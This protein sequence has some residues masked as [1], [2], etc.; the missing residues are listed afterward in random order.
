MMTKM[1]KMRSVSDVAEKHFHSFVGDIGFR[2]NVVERLLADIAL[3]FFVTVM[4]FKLEKLL[5]DCLHLF[6][7]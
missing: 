5:E 1:K 7:R 4:R 2:F 3:P 6:G